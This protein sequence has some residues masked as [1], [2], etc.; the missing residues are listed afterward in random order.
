M[1]LTRQKIVLT[2]SDSSLSGKINPDCEHCH[3]L[4]DTTTAAFTVTLP[5]VTGTMQR[6]LIFKNIGANSVTLVPITGQ[7]ID[8]SVSLVLTTLQNQSLYA[9][10]VKTW[11]KI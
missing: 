5:S 8:T 1:K 10:N 9:D 6:E 3:V 2:P 4:C 11:W 7:Y